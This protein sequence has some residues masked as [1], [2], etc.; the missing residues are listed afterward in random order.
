MV[1]PSRSA[2]ASLVWP[3]AASRRKAASARW[4]SWYARITFSPS[5][6]TSSGPSMPSPP[7]EPLDTRWW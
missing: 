7:V 3:F 4:K 1:R 5:L 2:T 6:P